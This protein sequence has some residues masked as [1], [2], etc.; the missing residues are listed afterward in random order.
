MFIY[1]TGMAS[2]VTATEQSPSTRYDVK[3]PQ[4]PRDRGITP[5]RDNDTSQK[6]SN[7]CLIS[8]LLTSKLLSKGY[9]RTKL[10]ST[11]KKFYGRQHDLDD[12]Y[13]VAASKLVTDLMPIANN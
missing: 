2:I 3:T 13:S 4:S 12:P 10:V 8:K 11:L 7:S 6:T 9:R 1:A 5:Q